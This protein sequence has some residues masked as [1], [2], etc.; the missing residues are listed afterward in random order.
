MLFN[1]TLSG[2]AAAV[3]ALLPG[4]ATLKSH[5]T[6]YFYTFSLSFRR[7]KKKKKKTIQEEEAEEEEDIEE[8]CRKSNRLKERE[9]RKQELTTLNKPFCVYKLPGH[10]VFKPLSRSHIR[11]WLSTVTHFKSMTFYICGLIT[12]RADGQTGQ[13]SKPLQG[14]IRFLKSLTMTVQS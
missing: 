10:N 8:H 7:G 2:L 5:E 11:P 13:I 6:G 3:C 4:H 14:I 12:S 9:N 1:T